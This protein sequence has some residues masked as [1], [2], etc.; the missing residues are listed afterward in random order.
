MSAHV[1]DLP[2]TSDGLLFVF[3]SH[4]GCP[5]ADAAGEGEAA[6]DCWPGVVA[7]RSG[8]TE[9]WACQPDE[10]AGVAGLAR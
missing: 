3:W 9:R 4:P 7:G 1:G 2:D 6:H 10:D 5:L 8:R